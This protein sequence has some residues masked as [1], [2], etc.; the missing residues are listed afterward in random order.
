[1]VDL[2]EKCLEDLRKRYRKIEK[3]E[4]VRR[5]LSDARKRILDRKEEERQKNR[6]INDYISGNINNYYHRMHRRTRGKK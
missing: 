4:F 1:M 6:V 3:E 5:M 2:E